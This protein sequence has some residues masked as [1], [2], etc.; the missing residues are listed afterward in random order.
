ML[1][2]YIAPFEPWGPYIT[3]N[4]STGHTVTFRSRAV[5][6]ESDEQLLWTT[7]DAQQKSFWINQIHAGNAYVTLKVN[8]DQTRLWIESDGKVDAALDMIAGDFWPE[9]QV[10]PNWAIYGKGDVVAEGYTSRMRWLR[11][12]L[13]W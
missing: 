10:M 6:R 7:P 2:L 9:G 8:A 5:G 4:L 1:V 12:I 11:L 3:A 13:P